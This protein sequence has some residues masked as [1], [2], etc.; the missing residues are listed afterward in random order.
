MIVA[1][2][3]AEESIRLVTDVLLLSLKRVRRC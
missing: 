2:L 3:L 1:A